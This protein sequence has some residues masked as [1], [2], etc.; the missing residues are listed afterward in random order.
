ML[1]AVTKCYYKSNY[2]ID[3]FLKEI[4]IGFRDESS[5]QQIEKDRANKRSRKHKITKA[6]KKTDLSLLNEPNDSGDEAEADLQLDSE[7]L[8]D[9]NHL[10][11]YLVSPI[12]HDFEFG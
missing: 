1:L 4:N 12:K 8:T 3:S 5:N 2:D 9:D 11:D 7:L 6:R 10:L